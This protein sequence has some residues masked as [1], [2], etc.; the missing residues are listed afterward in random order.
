V[1]VMLAG[2][3]RPAGSVTR[4][5]DA[6]LLYASCGWGTPQRLQSTG[7]QLL[8]VHDAC[9][10]TA[11]RAPGVGWPILQRCDPPSSTLWL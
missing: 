9:H 6:G 10:A 8:C 3:R 5:L 11:P 1:R 7:L 2:Q 4:C